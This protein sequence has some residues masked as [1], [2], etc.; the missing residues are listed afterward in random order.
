[1]P[2]THQ[3]KPA[4]ARPQTW[5]KAVLTS[6]ALYLALLAALLLH[7]AVLFGGAWWHL[8]WR[9]PSKQRPSIMVQLLRP[10]SPPQI[11]QPAIDAAA[12]P[13]ASSENEQPPVKLAEAAQKKTQKEPISPAPQAAA[14][15]APPHPTTPITP[16]TPAQAAAEAA[17]KSEMSLLQDMQAPD[18]VDLQYQL[19]GKN[20]EKTADSAS[21][22]W[23]KQ[24]NAHYQL[25]WQQSEG[26]KSRQMHSEGVLGADGLQP[27]R[28]SESGSDKSEVATHFVPDTQQIVFS[29]NSPAALLPA[30]V[31]DRLSVLMQLGGILAAQYEAQA[32]SDA[33]EI[34][35]ASSSQMRLWRWQVL[36]LQPA[37]PAVQKNLGEDANAHWLAVQHDPQ[38]DGGLP[39]EPTITVWYDCTNFMPMRIESRYA[40]GQVQDA[41]LRGSQ[42]APSPLTP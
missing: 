36:G 1:M 5:L 12:P 37:L 32:L 24:E 21:L 34:P 16:A 35:V 8:P 28:Y 14:T 19:V 29:N 25:L 10:P 38:R 15:P 42:T 13:Q 2:K 41:Q 27:L 30:G 20:G 9:L 4:A 7:T 23:E 6:P 22:R 3:K 18:S 39:W 40:S 26:G 11:A 33:I 17:D 31:Q